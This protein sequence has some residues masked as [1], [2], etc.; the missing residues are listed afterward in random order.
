M[1]RVTLH[2]ASAF[3]KLEQIAAGMRR[4][5][6]PGFDIGGEKVYLFFVEGWKVQAAY[7]LG[8]APFCLVLDRSICFRVGHA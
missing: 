2:E 5:N 1:K 7:D 4:L 6:R 8:L 3:G